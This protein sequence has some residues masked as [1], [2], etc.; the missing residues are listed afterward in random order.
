MDKKDQDEDGRNLVTSALLFN[1]EVA[2]SP[3]HPQLVGSEIGLNDLMEQAKR[4]LSRDEEEEQ[5]SPYHEHD[6]LF[7]EKDCAAS[8]FLHGVQGDDEGFFAGK[9]FFQV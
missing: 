4:M 9:R 8:I 7:S 1:Q 5:A 6:S 2:A 3:P